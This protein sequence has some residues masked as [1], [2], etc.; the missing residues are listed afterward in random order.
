MTDAVI[1]ARGLGKRY[2][3][4]THSRPTS[5]SDR[6][7]L[8]AKR[9]RGRAAA[10]PLQPLREEIWALRDVS[11]EVRRGEVLG[12]IGPNGAGKSTLLSILARITDPS[13]GEAE[14]RGR[15]SSLLEVGTGFHPELSGKDN[16]FLN[17][18]VLGMSRTETAAKFDEIVEFSGVRDFID[19]PVKR[20]STGMYV[21][22]A[23]SVAAHL[24]PEILLLDEVFAV[25][26]RAFQEK[27]LERITEMTRSG[28]TVLFVSHDVSSVARLCDHAIVLNEGRLVFHGEVDDAIARYLSSRSLGGGASAD[29]EREGSG[30]ARIA[31]V[32]VVPADDAQGVRSDR[33]L[34][35]RVEIS[36]RGPIDASGLRLQLGIHHSLG[37]E[38]VGLSTDFDPNRPLEGVDL[39]GGATIV[40]ELDELPLKP[41]TYYVSAALERPGGDLVDRVTK[42][43]P[44]A[45]VPTDF[46]GTGIVPG[47]T[48]HA[49]VLVRHRWE[50]EAHTPEL[51]A[52]VAAR[53]EGNGDD[54]D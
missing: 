34:S 33:P 32:S 47:E 25:G 38:Y 19:M 4:W 2:R 31:R 49:P 30:E 41:G 51:A 44:F 29:E 20:Y 43:A 46:F 23:F 12:V 35:I 52:R 26:D 40:C 50:V 14:L 17:G 45:V 18:A 1:S 5:L 54:D 8:T 15:V 27:C 42:Q 7:A 36:A 53:A 37:G 3:I 13:E 39:G 6:V 21:R 16:V 28:R 11:F 9:M 24:D 48:H 22:L 10:K